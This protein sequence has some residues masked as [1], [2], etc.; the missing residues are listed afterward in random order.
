MVLICF[1]CDICPSN[2]SDSNQ[3]KAHN[4]I[5]KGEKPFSCDKCGGKFR[6]RHHL[7]HHVCPMDDKAPRTNH[8]QFLELKEQLLLRYTGAGFPHTGISLPASIK[9][10]SA[11]DTSDPSNPSLSPDSKETGSGGSPTPGEADSTG[12][13]RRSRKQKPRRV[14][15][16]QQ[17]EGP[18]EGEMSPRQLHVSSSFSH[19]G[20][21]PVMPE[22]T[23]PE[24]LTI[25]RNSQD[26]LGQLKHDMRA[27]LS[28]D[29]D[30]SQAFQKERSIS[31]YSMAAYAIKDDRSDRSEEGGNREQFAGFGD[32]KMKE[33]D[34]E[35]GRRSEEGSTSVSDPH[36]A[37]STPGDKFR[38]EADM[39]EEEEDVD[40]G[41][42]PPLSSTPFLN[43]LFSHQTA[44]QLGLA[45]TAMPLATL[46]S[47]QRAVF[48]ADKEAEWEKN[49]VKKEISQQ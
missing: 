31:Q 43:P 32:T 47:H 11:E 38:S 1:Q 8:G 29:G 36:S 19:D 10:P 6:R 33:E 3:L 49:H 13:K 22:Q 45:G 14:I 41:V 35:E 27:R 4:L 12:E 37:H 18:R 28:R 26:Q 34:P 39:E 24:D 25:F 42:S 7:M 15:Q 21:S 9:P 40:K 16:W 23:E 48:T 30:L 5:H 2:F 20:P 17:G 46:A 44:I